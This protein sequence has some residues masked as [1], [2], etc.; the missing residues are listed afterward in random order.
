M[1]RSTNPAATTAFERCIP[2]RPI[3]ELTYRCNF[4]CKHCYCVVPD[5]KETRARELTTEEWIDVIDQL[6]AL[7]ALTLTLTGGEPLLRRD[8]FEIAQHARE[9]RFALRIFSNASLLSEEKIAKI[10]DL[11]PLSVDVSLYG[12]NQQTYTAL[13]GRGAR[14]DRVIAHLR[15]LKRSGLKIL[16]KLPV[17]SSSVDDL[18]E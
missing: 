18:N 12:A 5:T 15:A 1:D 2:L 7:G 11:K 17:T 10:V 13:A 6:A 8:F 4:T 14:F 3:L 16:V 9:R